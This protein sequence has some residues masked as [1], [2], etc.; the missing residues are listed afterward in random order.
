[1]HP[2]LNPSY[3]EVSDTPEPS[4]PPPSPPSP[5]FTVLLFSTVVG[6]HRTETKSLQ[7]Q[8]DF[9]VGE[10]DR[11]IY[12]T[13]PDAAVSRLPA[14]LLAEIFLFVIESALQGGNTRF[15]PGT[16]IF[17]HVCRRW[18]QVAVGCPRLW[19]WWIPGASKA[20]PL[21][22]SR[23]RGIPIFL[24]WRPQLPAS[25]RD[26]LI[27]PA[28]PERILG[29]DFIGT[30]EQ[31]AHFLGIFDSGTPA[32]ASSIRLKILPY[33]DQ[34][35]RERLFRFLSLSFPKLSRV[36]LENFLPDSSSLILTT[37]SLTSLKLTAPHEIE[38]R[39]TL[40]QLSRLLRRH[41]NLQEL[42]LSHGAIPLFGPSEASLVSF[43]LPRL[44]TLRLCG[45]QEAVSG[46]ADLIGIS[47]HLHTVVIRISN[48]RLVLYPDLSSAMKKVF[49]AYYGCQGLDH[50]RKFH[51][52][53]IS[54][55]T[56]TEDLTF[57]TRPVSTP[58]VKSILKFQFPRL[59]KESAGEI[60]PPFLLDDIQEFV[61]EG[62]DIYENRWC[63]RLLKMKNLS[64]LKLDNLED[65]RQVLCLMAVLEDRGMFKGNVATALVEPHVYR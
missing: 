32:N 17:L 31:L 22:N 52:F 3:S 39:Y 2:E 14:E 38:D 44:V 27:D 9:R 58:N 8:A 5:K 48:A 37:S 34:E 64:H 19:R 49:V 11:S 26:I 15:T 63:E 30:S 55:D 53:A 62:M 7:K 40:S 10:A 23:S 43:A 16:F 20:W 54:Y 25:A 12:T 21:F 47:S 56:A 42:D 59:H 60:T 4:A 18:N 33:D 6:Q 50:P 24:S 35:P 36:N 1:M 28:T 41:S 51:Q 57:S 29:L 61:F 46:F 65:A 13:N 45:T